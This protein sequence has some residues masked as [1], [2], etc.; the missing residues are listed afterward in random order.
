MRCFEQPPVKIADGRVLGGPLIEPPDQLAHRREIQAA[1]LLP[2][3]PQRQTAHSLRRPEEQCAAPVAVP[4]REGLPWRTLQTFIPLTPMS[5][6]M[7]LAGWRRESII[8][9]RMNRSS[10][11][12]T[13]AALATAPGPAGLAVI[14]ISG[15]ESL[16]LA[17]R[18]FRCAGLKPS[19]RPTHTVVAG[20][21]VAGHD[22]LDEALLLI[23][24][25]P[26]SYTREDVVEIQ[27]HGGLIASRRVLRC[28]LAAGARPAE[29]GEFT[30]RAFLNGRLDLVQAEA[31]NDLIRARSDRAAQ[32]AVEQLEGRLSVR[33]NEI[34]DALI[35]LAADVAAAL[36][37]PDD[38]LPPPVMADVLQR[39]DRVK[40]DLLALMATWDEG[41][42]LRDGLLVVIA[43]R[44]NVGKSTLMNTLLG[45]NRSI[46]SE[47][48]GT[49]RDTIEESLVLDGIQ[50]VLVDTAG[51]R[52]SSCPIEREG[53]RR[54][55]QKLEKADLYLYIVDAS[56]PQHPDDIKILQ[57]L[58]SGQCL[59][60]GNKTDLGNKFE[61]PAD[62]N[63]PYVEL[64]LL[65][66][67]DLESLINKIKTFISSKLTMG[68]GSFVAISERHRDLLF[69]AFEQ[70]VKS[71]ELLKEGSEEVLVLA[72]GH[73]REAAEIIGM[74]TGKEYH[75]EL[76]KS[77]FSKFC[78]GK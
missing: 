2:S 13:I 8:S 21:V 54:A 71:N 6:R 77:V 16:A 32:A 69:K 40:K 52:D 30:C 20:H 33:F 3:C 12:D 48:P 39:S 37:F 64:S 58:P 28:V 19:E 17:D 62:N 36:D 49:T 67:I 57:N 50:L 31:V 27:C 72:A 76:L 51:L 14:R 15:P 74:V 11:D 23:M 10:H 42:C 34:Y 43:G 9:A 45:K 59:V 41:H 26:R 55:R 73:L 5:F 70:I 61:L 18:V 24:R 35:G 44:P 7:P 53:V 25:A 65:Y 29:P 46:V 38:E 75:D 56:Q 4:F 68:H 78:V 63:M 60:V 47:I 22:V 66:N 1:R